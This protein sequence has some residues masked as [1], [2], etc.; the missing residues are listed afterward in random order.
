[1]AK[2]QDVTDATFEQ[3]VLKAQGPVLVDFWAA[4]CGPCRAVAPVL[5]EIAQEQAD[6]LTIKKLDVD[7]NQ[8]T[9]GQ[10]GIM[11]IPAMVLFRD[12]QPVK[13]I[14]GARPKAAIMREI[15]PYLTQAGAKS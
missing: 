13:Q 5:D 8:G 12:G 6:K 10:Y 4:W 14:V 3:E 15:E 11:S 7:Q 1:M 9:A 2:P